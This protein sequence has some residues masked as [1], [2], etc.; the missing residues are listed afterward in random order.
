MQAAARAA[1][2]EKQGDAGTQPALP[3]TT[4]PSGCR[5]S[6][7][8]P[9]RGVAGGSPRGV[10][11]GSPR[12][13]AGGGG[14]GVAGAAV[15]LTLMTVAGCRADVAVLLVAAGV[16]GVAS[17]PAV[18]KNSIQFTVLV[19]SLAHLHNKIMQYLNPPTTG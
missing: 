18:H 17:G 11:G 15:P 5:E 14:V 1:S 6:S 2:E 19:I 12:G 3:S 8:G 9:G 7:W 10:A 13:V 16:G 4:T